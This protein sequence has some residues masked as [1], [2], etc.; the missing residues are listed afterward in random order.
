MGNL[1]QTPLFESHLR[2]KAKMT[3]FHGWNLPL[4]YESMLEEVRATRRHASAFDVSHM[5]QLFIEGERAE[6]FLQ[7]VVTSDASRLQNG[8]ALYTLLCQVNGGLVDDVLLYRF[9]PG[10]YMIITNAANT[11]SVY[12]WLE[13]RRPARLLVEDRSAAWVQI[14][15]QG[16]QSR[17]L[18]E[19]ISAHLL[20]ELA[21]FQFIPEIDIAGH[22]CL[23]SRT[24]Y[25]GED[26]FEL[27]CDTH[28]APALW[29]KIVSA[30]KNNPRPAT[31]AGLGARDILRLEAGFPL[32]G[33]ELNRHT[34]PLEAGLE[35]FVDLQEH[36]PPFIG[37]E[38]LRGQKLSG[39]PRKLWGLIMQ[40]RTIPRT[41]Y[42]LRAAGREI[43]LVTSGCYSPTL[44]KS[45]G[46]AF[47]TTREA[48]EGRDICVEVRGKEKPA[49]LVKLPFYRRDE[50]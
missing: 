12:S 3:G 8:R 22:Q 5:G 31:P 45:I 47:L 18:L 27:L 48:W 4:Q 11:T 10:H 36:L 43:G 39:L 13:S 49:R 2:L 29:D 26:G 50:K 25:T 21:A 38:A 24:G 42:V 19:K 46:M 15:V 35:K 28:A 1:R 9:K 16:P 6:E 17:D 34:T 40:E 7:S 23:L 32:Y 37:R 14:A 44:Q 20:T 30:S 33:H 41:G